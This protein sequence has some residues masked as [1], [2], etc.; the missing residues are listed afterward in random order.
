LRLSN[1][2]ESGFVAGWADLGCSPPAGGLEK[3]NA[4]GRHA[5]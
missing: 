5:Y 3:N 2:F 4:L 1:F